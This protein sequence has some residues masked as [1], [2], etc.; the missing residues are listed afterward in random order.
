MGKRIKRWLTQLEL[1]QV[2]SDIFNDTPLDYYKNVP[3][4]FNPAIKWNEKAVKG[5][6]LPGEEYVQLAKLDFQYAYTSY[7]R[8]LNTATL[9][10]LAATIT[11]SS[12]LFYLKGLGVTSILKHAEMGWDH[13]FTEMFERYQEN[14]WNF[15]RTKSYSNRVLRSLK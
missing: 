12:M 9:R 7:A 1:E 8:I 13:D 10:Q 6:L 4:K 15:K 11:G 3:I 14:G 5:W 2:E